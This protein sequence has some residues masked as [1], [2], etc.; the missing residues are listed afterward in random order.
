MDVGLLRQVLASR[1][2]RVCAAHDPL[3][4]NTSSDKLRP[5]QGAV[6]GFGVLVRPGRAPYNSLRCGF[7]E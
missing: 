2:R 1:T 3:G 4:T 7:E 6:N 5:A